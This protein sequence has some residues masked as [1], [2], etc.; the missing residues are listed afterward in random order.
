[1]SNP[2][3]RL[4]DLLPGQPVQVGVV[5]AVATD[6][7]TVALR[8]GG[9]VKARGTANLNAR[10]YVQDGIVLGP[11]PNLNGTDIEV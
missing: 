4:I 6:G 8:E 5:T 1:M 9:T 2:Y 11:A 3:K 10:V 7:V